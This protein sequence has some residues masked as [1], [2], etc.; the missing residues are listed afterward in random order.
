MGQPNDDPLIRFLRAPWDPAGRSQAAAIDGAELVQQALAQGVAPLLYSRLR[1]ESRLPPACLEP[2]RQAYYATA[3]HNARLLHELEA[4]LGALAAAGIPVLLLKGAALAQAVYDN[5]AVRPMG[6]VDLLV[7]PADVDAALQALAG[8]GYVPQHHEPAAGSTRTYENELLLGRPG[9]IPLEVHWSFFDSPYY[10]HRLGMEWFWET[11]VPV[12]PGTE[13]LP[14]GAAHGPP[15]P[16]RGNDHRRAAA[17][18]MLG[19]EAQVLHLC[20]HLL[21]HH[22]AAEQLRLLWLHDIAEV[23]VRYRDRLD[24]EAL[25]TQAQ[26]FELVLPLQQLLPRLAAE[27]RVP[28]PAAVLARLARLRPSKGESRT[29]AE[30][31]SPHRPPARRLWADLRATPGWRR[32]LRMFWVN[33]VPTPAYMRQRYHI[34]HPLLAPFYYPYRWLLGLYGAVRGKRG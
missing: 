22:G 3:A 25:L 10:Q 27:W 2:L 17:A 29:L 5:P 21:L 14:A 18:R 13:T 33:M 11:A 26:R 16:E 31:T 7:R 20:A 4:I 28:L 1:G 15:L 8:L 34:P 19:P 30:L 9:G 12:A 6:D 32:R 24:W 23:L